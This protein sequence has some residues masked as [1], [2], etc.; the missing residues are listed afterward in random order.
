MYPF[1][2]VR[3]VGHCVVRIDGQPFGEFCQ[4]EHILFIQILAV[5]EVRD[6]RGSVRLP[7]F[8]VQRR[9]P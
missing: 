2:V 7:W 8:A 9:L 5:E 6:A 1:A 3:P 4:S